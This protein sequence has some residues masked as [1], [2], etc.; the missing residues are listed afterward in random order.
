YFE[1]GSSWS[2]RESLDVA[3]TAAAALQRQGVRAGDRVSIILPNGADWLRAWWGAALL[4]A[5]IVP[6]NPTFV[7]RILEEL[8]E[9]VDAAFIITEGQMAEAPPAAKRISPSSLAAPHE[10]S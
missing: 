5:V 2:R 10:G 9:T 3:V 4:G 7:G 8:L 6:F 1:D